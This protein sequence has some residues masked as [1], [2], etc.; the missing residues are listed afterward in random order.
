MIT[1]KIPIVSRYLEKRSNLK[2]PQQWLLNAL[3]Y[4]PVSSGVNVTEES[5]MQVTAVFAC[6]RVLSWTLAS[7]PFPVYKRL[8]PRGKERAP[9]HPVYDLLHDR[10]NEYQTSFVYRSTAMAH[11]QLWGNAYSEIETDRFGN[12][13][14]LWQLPP[15]RVEPKKSKQGLIFYEVKLADGTTKQVPY[16]NMLHIMGL[17]IDGLKGMSPI[18]QAQEAIGLAKAAE[19]FGGRFFAQGTNA[20]GVVEHPGK[21]SETAYT[22]LQKSLKEKYEG[23]GNSH[24]LL[25]LEEGMKFQKVGIPPNEAQFLETRSFQVP[26]IAR[27]YGVPL[28]LI[29]ETT[30]STSWGSGLEEQNLGFVVHTMRPWFVNWEQEV[31]RKLFSEKE[32]REY[33][34]EFL[35]DGLLRGDLKSRYDSYAVGR[36]WGWLSVNDINELEN[37]N[38][39]ENGDIYLQPMNMVEAGTEYQPQAKVGT[40][41]VKEENSLTHREQ[42]NTATRH[43]VALSYQRVFADAEARILRREEADVM[44]AAKRIFGDSDTS[45]FLDWLEGFYQSHP[46]FVQKNMLPPVA[47]LAEAIQAE[48]AGELDIEAGMTPELEKFTREFVEAYTIRHIESSQGQI[49][50]VVNQAADEGLDQVDALQERFDEWRERRPEKVAKNET[51]KLNGAVTRAVMAAAGVTKLIWR[52]MGSK[53]CPFC[54][55][56]DGKVV[57]ID[58]PFIVAG[59]S[60]EADDGSGMRVYGPKLHPPIH[61]GCVC[62]IER[63]V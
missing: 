60:I 30:K 12:P 40:P 59:Q 42:R 18:R 49:R 26:D 13:V 10:P 29:Q 28:H 47:S 41:A 15:W 32:R 63:G 50:Q 3:G 25:L 33:F 16:Y 61:Q 1:I 62:G 58:E 5:A 14:A 39:V 36:Q 57:G 7:L 24:R 35:V 51:I 55:Q 46:D 48:L 20:G 23:L 22:N 52:N 44:R 56:L 9:D 17:G 45:A 37:R 11:L 54:E 53:T 43:R 34:A 31:K 19:E 27:I 6:V 2:D 4:R 38:P 8:K 21:L